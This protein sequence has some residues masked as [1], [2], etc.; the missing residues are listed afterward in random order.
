M[1]LGPFCSAA[2]ANNA[3]ISFLLYDKPHV[4]VSIV[5]SAMLTYCNPLLSNSEW[6]RCYIHLRILNVRHFGM[7]KATGIEK[8]RWGHL[9]RHHIL[10][11]FHP[12]PPISSKIHPPQNFKRSSLRN[13]W[14]REIKEYGVEVTF[15]VITFLKIFIQIHRSV[16]NY[17]G[18]SL[19]PTQKFKRPPFL[20][21]WSYGIKKWDVDGITCVPNFMKIHRVLHFPCLYQSTVALHSHLSPCVWTIGLLVAAVQRHRVTPLALITTNPMMTSYSEHGC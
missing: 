13:T 3:F 11:E 10:T 6:W 20:S 14:S 1:N 5:T 21:D 18:V 2:K 9:Q 7:V 8:W 16:Q 4:F 15:N 12:N 17:W 19:H